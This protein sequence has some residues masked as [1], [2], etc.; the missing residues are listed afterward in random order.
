MAI[1]GYARVSSQDQ[2]LDIQIEQLQNAG[3]TKIFS[4]KK[5]GTTTEG[6]QEFDRCLQYLRDGDTLMVTRIDRMSRSMADFF[7]TMGVLA[8]KQVGFKVLLQPEI[9]TSTANGRLIS[10]IFMAMAEFEAAIRKERQ[11]E[12]IERAKLKGVYTNKHKP[13]AK[14]PQRWAHC[15]RLI[16]T[17]M[18]Y[19]EVA[20]KMDVSVSSLEHR[21]GPRD[22]HRKGNQLPQSGGI[23]LPQDSA[24]PTSPSAAETVDGEA[25]S[26]ADPRKPAFLRGLF[27]RQ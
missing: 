2:N 23:L 22:S 25:T 5:S 4:E 21:F 8:E 15:S 20:A 26:K 27:G 12:G 13:F 24:E 6:R 18:S 9:D 14:P 1:V 17:G 7:K 11:R 19:E 16:N 3:C 10:G